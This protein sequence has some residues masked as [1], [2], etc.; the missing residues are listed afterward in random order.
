ME[1]DVLSCEKK[2]CH[3]SA[4]SDLFDRVRERDY[5]G[6]VTGLQPAHLY[7]ALGA[8]GIF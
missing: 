7:P 6:P 4:P 2:Y 8:R 5:S 1:Q 3:L